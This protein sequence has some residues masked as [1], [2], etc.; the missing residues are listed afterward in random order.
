MIEEMPA[1]QEARTMA[2]E[3]A[4]EWLDEDWERG[5]A[6]VAHPD[7]LEYGAAGAIARWTAQGKHITYVL[8]TSGEAGIDS[9]EPAQTCVVR[10]EEE[11]RSARAVG[12]D[13]VEFL[14]YPDGIVEYGL[15]LRRDIARMVRRYRP[16]VLI[17]AN[18]HLT[19][20]GGYVNMADHRAVGLA[21]LDGARDAGNR[22]VFP[23]LLAEGLEPVPGGKLV[24]FSGSPEPTHAVD[25]TDFLDRGIASLREHVEYIKGLGGDFDIDAFLRSAAAGVGQRVGCELAVSFEVLH[26]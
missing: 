11:R 2:A 20:G 21:L 25:V 15:P 3:Q 8:V 22:W 24:C 16:Q 18:Y 4:L 12:V 9:M 6:V 5:L 1:G 23:E 14:G 10:E 19:W 17:G 7:D 13:T 26:V